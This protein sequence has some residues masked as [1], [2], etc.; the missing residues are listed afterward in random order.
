MRIVNMDTLR[1]DGFAVHGLHALF[2]HWKDGY[3]YG[4]WDMHGD[5][6]YRDGLVLYIRGHARYTDAQGTS[7]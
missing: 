3:T 7:P 4:R 1:V 5:G 6:Q 2:C